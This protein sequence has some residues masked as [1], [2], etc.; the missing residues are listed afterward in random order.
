[1][2]IASGW[3][4]LAGE[5]RGAAPPALTASA[6][7]TGGLPAVAARIDLAQKTLRVRGCGGL[8][9][10]A[11]GGDVTTIPFAD[12]IDPAT[13]RI[14]AIK[15]GGGRH[16][17]HVV[18][19]SATRP[20]V[21][22]EAIVAGKTGNAAT[23]V[24]SGG[25][26]LGATGEAEGGRILVEGDVVYVGELRR[27]LT[28]CGQPETLLVPKRLDPAT[29]T[30]HSVA[31]PRIPKLVRDTATK[32]TGLPVKDAPIGSILGLRGASTND[33]G[34]AALLDDDLATAW[35]ETRKGDGRGEFVVFSSTKA[36]PIERLSFVLAPSK[37]IAGYAP[38]SSLFVVVDGATFSV[39]LPKPT[40]DGAG[41]RVDVVFPQPR[42]TS[43]V[44][45]E[46]DRA[47][48]DA[49]DDPVVGFAEIE[50]VPVVPASVHTLD[51]L[52][53]LLDAGGE[54][55]DLAKSL[56]VHAGARGAK[57]V[58]GKLGTVGDRGK[59]LAVEVLE[60][61]P[62]PA[63]APGLVRLSWDAPKATVTA[64]RTALDACGV[65]AKGAIAE[66]FG[67]GSA[68]VREAIA[69]RYARLDPKGALGAILGVVPASTSGRRRTFRQALSRVAS[70]KA[71]RS[72]IA[73]W[74]AQHE[75]A[76][77]PAETE[78]DPTIELARAIAPSSSLADETDGG[79][80][81]PLLSRVLLAHAT[82]DRP[83]SRR[84]L[85]A[86]PIAAL[87]ARADLPSLAWMRALFVSPDRYLRMRAAEVAGALE[88]LRPELLRALADVDPRVRQRA[89]DALRKSAPPGVSP[90][91]KTML[92]SDAWT[93]VRVS[94]AD[95][96]GDL[97]GGGDVDVALATATRD[98][99]KSVRS[100]SLRALATRGARSQLAAVRARAFDAEEAVDVRREAIEALGLLCDTDSADD[101]FELAKRL[102]DSDAARML[103][104]A[105]IVALGEI[106]PKDLAQRLG[107]L[108]QS[109]LVVKD[110]VG[111]ALRTIGR[112]K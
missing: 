59:E 4:I 62:C 75:S 107:A 53:T 77:S 3:M 12:A 47:Q 40:S 38:P 71:G 84:W 55:A 18:V 48:V 34:S 102:G 10:D 61:T 7:P 14:D 43:C 39:T 22:W 69:E 13:S 86:E 51:D 92:A 109:S 110:A 98:P 6:A 78:V 95:L 37:P 1:L 26:G 57:A 79:P 11:A 68:V 2:A 94:A 36:L 83:F 9:C 76:P 74:L 85:A 89:L 27:E 63:A 81:P 23:V 90:T 106:H 35:T 31:M 50:G 108:E 104:L 88:P 87:A 111:R 25:T 103:G 96:L 5:S 49:K 60:S 91:V 24:W 82:A 70:T 66:A 33:G 17:L 41:N 100:A 52:V 29:M 99:A 56:L 42:S 16:V 45:I 93:F 80:L 112:C 67:S 46:L 64:A 101:L 28:I 44:A 19:K 105:A 30:L 97:Q 15:V 73:E 54:P 32:L 65:A 58:I 21:A 20:T 72:A 8:P